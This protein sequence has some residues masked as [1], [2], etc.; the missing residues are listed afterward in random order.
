M[1]RMIVRTDFGLNSPRSNILPTSARSSGLVDR[2]FA[3]TSKSTGHTSTGRSA[4]VAESGTS[5]ALKSGSSAG[6]SRSI[7]ISGSPCSMVTR[8]ARA[9]GVL[10]DSESSP[11]GNEHRRRSDQR[12][13]VAADS[14]VGQPYA[15]GRWRASTERAYDYYLLD[16][17]LRRAVL[18]FAGSRGMRMAKPST[19]FK[20]SREGCGSWTILSPFATTA[21][22]PRG[23]SPPLST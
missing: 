14:P 1:R 15:K 12:L 4:I 3:T 10:G 18:A 11:V 19:D 21:C 17:R 8:Q 2:N 5:M 7:R 13:A 20:P 23:F 9:V 16:A 22:S 6:T